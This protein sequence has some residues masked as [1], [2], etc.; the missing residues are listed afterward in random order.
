MEKSR[1]HRIKNSVL[2]YA[3]I[4]PTVLFIVMFTILP[5]FNSFRDSLFR[6]EIAGMPR[7]FVGIQNYTDLFNENHFIGASFRRVLSNTFVF[8]VAVVGVSLPTAFGFALLVRQKSRLSAFVRFSFFH[9]SLLP[10][11][12]AA[13]IWAF[14]YVPNSGL[15][16]TILRGW[17]LNSIG[18]LGDPR[19]V[20]WSIVAVMVWKQSGYFMIYYLA[21]LQAVSREVHEAA[22]VEGVT[23]WQ[24]LHFITLPLLMRT[25]QF[26]LTIGVIGAFQWV[27]QLAALGQGAP[28]N[29]GNLLLYFILQRLGETRN[30]GYVNAMT[31]FIIVIVFSLTLINFLIFERQ[32]R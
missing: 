31:V 29:H 8:V 26:V 14:L 10:T 22:T 15:F 5:A 3:F 9:P 19:L 30:W 32:H 2:G 6:P 21:G 17:G 7:S 12:G 1:I 24:R 27:D 28:N 20:L 13:S 25:H 4:T 11:I 16:N 18:W 23:R